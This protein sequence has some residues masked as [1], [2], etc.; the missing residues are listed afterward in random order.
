MKMSTK[1]RQG[2]ELN[3]DEGQAAA[4]ASFLLS[5]E[6]DTQEECCGV[7]LQQPCLHSMNDTRS[8]MQH[9]AA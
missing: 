8:W 6:G 7:Q 1:F 4:S 5:I 9:A 3:A 2:A